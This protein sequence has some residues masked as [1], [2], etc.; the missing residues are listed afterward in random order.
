M[1]AAAIEA[2]VAAS[3]TLALGIVVMEICSGL[4]RRRLESGIGEGE[5]RPVFEF[6]PEEVKKSLK[7]V[8]KRVYAGVKELFGKVGGADKKAWKEGVEGMVTDIVD[9]KGQAATG[10]N[11]AT[12]EEIFNYEDEESVAAAEMEAGYAKSQVV[13]ND[14]DAISVVSSS[15]SATGEAGFAEG[16]GDV[17]AIRERLKGFYLDGDEDDWQKL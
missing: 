8:S 4:L 16:S 6:D 13:M 15:T 17:D 10:P 5:G 2:P 9:K 3:L 7:V 14:I 11:S 1:A 12:T